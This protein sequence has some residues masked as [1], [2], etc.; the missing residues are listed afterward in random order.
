MDPRPMLHLTNS[1]PSCNNSECSQQALEMGLVNTVVPLDKL[2]EE[3]VAWC[4][5]ILSNSPMALRVGQKQERSM[6]KE[7]QGK[8]NAVA[9]HIPQYH[10]LWS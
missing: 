4:R 5:E 7:G 3:T 6:G 2:E 1:L 8:I 10:P 9:P